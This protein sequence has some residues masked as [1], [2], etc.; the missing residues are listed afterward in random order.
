MYIHFTEA[1]AANSLT[2]QLAQGHSDNVKQSITLEH[3][4]TCVIDK[5]VYMYILLYILE[6]IIQTFNNI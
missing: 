3:I 5:N 4:Y 1:S 6:I 2:D